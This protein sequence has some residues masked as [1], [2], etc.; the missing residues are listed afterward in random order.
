M[1]A[2]NFEHFPLVVDLD[3]TLIAT[4]TLFEAVLV[5][6][7]RSPW[8]LFLLPLWLFLGRAELKSKVCERASLNAA[9]LPYRPDFVSWLLV[10][11]EQGRRLVL[12]TAADRAVAQAVQAHLGL[13]SDVL[14]SDGSSNLKGREKLRAIQRLLGADFVYAGDSLADLPIWRAAN[15]AVVVAPK[16]RVLAKLRGVSIEREFLNGA[17]DWQAFFKALRVHQWVKNLL[18]FVPVLTAFALEPV[19]LGSLVVAFAAFSLTASAT[20]VFNDLWDLESDRAHPVKCRRPFASGVISIPAG[21]SAALACLALGV[22]LAAWVKPA[23]LLCL[24]VYLVATISYSWSLKTYVL[25]DVLVL[26]FLYTLRILA[27]AVALG[28]FVTPWL[29]AYS[30][31]TFLSLALVKRCAEL[32]TMR[33]AG[34]S[35]AR[36]RDYRLTDLTVL[37]PMG[38]GTAIASIVVFGLFVSAPDTQ[39]RY[40]TPWLLWVTATALTYWLGR[41][42]LKT[43]RSEMHDD[44]VVY[45]MKDRGS[46]LTIMAILLTTIIARSIALPS[47]S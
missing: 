1:S 3:G 43:S 16:A 24:I 44:P 47:L 27:G 2:N 20:Y 15:A 40:A 10:Q 39:E 41:I 4:D 17:F 32:N 36:G 42:W 14:A 38:V 33:E 45:A 12:A 23:F 29:L 22:A 28:V 25:L 31:F 19:Q 5:L 8:V 11:R 30:M 7:K 37:W 18:L 6:L 46:R 26:A 21:I 34:R 9:N 13:F 35:S